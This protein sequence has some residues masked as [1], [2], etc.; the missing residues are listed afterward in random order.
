VYFMDGVIEISQGITKRSNPRP[1]IVAIITEGPDLSNRHFRQVLDPL[2]TAGAAL[3][4]VTIG[5]P[6]TWKTTE[7]WSS[8][9]GR[10]KAGA[11]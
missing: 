9:W 8:T 5:S 7:I 4:I 1:V 2:R 3:H 6:R 11:A 10:D